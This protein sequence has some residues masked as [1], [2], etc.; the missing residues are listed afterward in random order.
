MGNGDGAAAGVVEDGA[1]TGMIALE[2]GAAGVAAADVFR[3]LADELTT[4]KLPTPRISP[5]ESD[6]NKCYIN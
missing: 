6:R 5:G 1:S 4:C 2:D 3:F